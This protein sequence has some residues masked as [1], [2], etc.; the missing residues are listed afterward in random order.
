MKHSAKM[1]YYIVSIYERNWQIAWI[2]TKRL[3]ALQKVYELE[4]HYS[5]RLQRYEA[6][7]D[8]TVLVMK[9]EPL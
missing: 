1:R 4:E 9:D 6:D 5:V 8:G 2:G 3:L 7:E